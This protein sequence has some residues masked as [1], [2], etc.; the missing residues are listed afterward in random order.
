MMNDLVDWDISRAFIHDRD[1][2]FLFDFWKIVFK[3]LS[4]EFLISTIYHSQIDE[5][6]ERTNQ[7]VEIALK[8]TLTN[9]LD[10]NWVVFL[11]TLRARLNNLSNAVIDLS[12]NEVIMNFKIRDSLALLK[13][14][15]EDKKWLQKRAINRTKIE[16]AIVWANIRAKIIYDRHHRSLVLQSGD[17][18]YL[19]LHKSYSLSFVK[20]VKLFIQRVGFFR[21]LERKNNL[22]YK[23]NLLKNWKIHSIIFVVNLEFVSKGEN[24]YDRSA[25]DHLESIFEFNQ[26]WHVYEIEKLIEYRMRR[27]DREILIFEFLVRWKSY[28]SKWDRWYDEDLLDDAQK[29]MQEY[30]KEHGMLVNQNMRRSNVTNDAEHDQSIDR[31]IDLS[32]ISSVVSLESTRRRSERSRKAKSIKSAESK[33]QKIQQISVEEVAQSKRRERSSKK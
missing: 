33:I 32:S 26:K 31:T 27:Y 14:D 18:V 21:I 28:E 1:R 11:L 24:S 22:V 3:K 12:L 4:V 7:I 9:N 29:L 19:R 15:K 16:I 5:Q 10:L 8:Y 13:F 30:K 6:S 2:K 23:L 20:F 17:R 25:L